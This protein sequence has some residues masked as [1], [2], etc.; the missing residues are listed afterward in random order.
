MNSGGPW[1]GREGGGRKNM[2]SM[3]KRVRSVQGL[4]VWFIT[5][6]FLAMCAKEEPR[7]QP[8]AF[9]NGPS[10]PAVERGAGGAP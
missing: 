6:A 5:L 3:T 9:E 10:A 4:V 2:G 7:A 8:G 1:G